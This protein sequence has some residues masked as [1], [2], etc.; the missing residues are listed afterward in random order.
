MEAVIPERLTQEVRRFQW[1]D[2]GRYL[3][4]LPE[5]FVDGHWRLGIGFNHEYLDAYWVYDDLEAAVKALETWNPMKEPQ[6]DGW[7]MKRVPP[8]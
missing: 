2:D 3:V 1:V 7:I 6:P 8:Q 4:I 5:L